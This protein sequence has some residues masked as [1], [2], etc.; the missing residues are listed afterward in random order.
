MK[1]KKAQIE[2]IFILLGL[3]FSL[4]GFFALY[5][6][7]KTGDSDRLVIGMLAIGMVAL[8]GKLVSG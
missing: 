8:F 5:N 2:Q 4:I 3:I 1:H 6:G 7:L